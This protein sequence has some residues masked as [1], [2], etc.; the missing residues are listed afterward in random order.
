MT[1]SR[2]DDMCEELPSFSQSRWSFQ[3]KHF[4]KQY[5]LQTPAVGG[6]PVEWESLNFVEYYHRCAMTARQRLFE[7]IDA[8]EGFDI[9]AVPDLPNLNWYESKQPTAWRIPPDKWRR[10]WYKDLKKFLQNMFRMHEGE[11]IELL[12][13]WEPAVGGDDNNLWFHQQMATTETQ[14]ADLRR[15]S[16]P[17][18]S[19]DELGTL[20]A[21]THMQVR[22]GQ[23]CFRHGSAI[24][25][26]ELMCD[27][28][29]EYTFREL[30]F[31][32]LQSPK[33]VKKRTHP[34]GN[35]VER[36][37]AWVRL[38]EYGSFAKRRLS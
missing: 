16:S 32:Y 37:A 25:L 6:N 14:K 7:K 8:A 27:W 22:A 21:M 30:Y 28:V 4:Q 38:Y 17:T 24:T 3:A 26:P 12:G 1:E 2:Y 13:S 9:E 29:G 33:L 35:T 20:G 11:V 5:H 23:L 10:D 18:L 19:K 34:V 31:W 36:E 15:R